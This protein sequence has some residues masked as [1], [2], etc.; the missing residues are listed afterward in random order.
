MFFGVLK[1]ISSQLL[2]FRLVLTNDLLEDRHIDDFKITNTFFLF[3]EW[4]RVSKVK[5]FFSLMKMTR[6]NTG[7]VE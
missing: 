4:R 1:K 5:V 7:A 2:T 6:N 3:F